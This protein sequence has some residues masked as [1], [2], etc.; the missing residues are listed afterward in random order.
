MSGLVAKAAT[1]FAWKA[2]SPKS[3]QTQAMENEIM[4]RPHSAGAFGTGGY[5]P[6][7]S[8]LNQ[9]SADNFIDSI[10]QAI[11]TKMSGVNTAMPG[12][13]GS[14]DAAHNRAT[15][16]PSIAK[17]LHDPDLEGLAPPQIINRPVIWP[18]AQSGKA[19]LTMPL[20]AGDG[21]MLVSQQR[22]LENWLS[23]NNGKP[24][25]PRQFDLTD[26]V[27]IPGLSHNAIVAHDKDVVLRFDKTEVRIK[28]GNIIVVGN[29]KGNITIDA[30][31]NITL[32]GQTIKIETPA[33]NFT[34]ETHVHTGVQAGLATTQPPQ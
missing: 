31:G 2:F 32:H 12:V 29:D 26:T 18:A 6:T 24:D 23:G 5:I 28:E 11:D 30:N 7:A 20:A 25:D 3:T 1:T 27:A 15:V 9:T 19:A 16:S 4:G 10:H 22:S 14:Y 34:L 8:P 21:V 17:R 13:I 33:R